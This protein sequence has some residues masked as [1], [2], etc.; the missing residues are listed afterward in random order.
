MLKQ[1]IRLLLSKFYSKQENGTISNLSFPDEKSLTTIVDEQPVDKWGTVCTFTAPSSGYLLARGNKTPNAGRM[2]ISIGC[3]SESISTGSESQNEI[4]LF[5]PLRKG[6]FAKVYANSVKALT[7]QFFKS[8][9]G[10]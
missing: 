7:V 5:V 8:V 6:T 10:G 4:S 9:G 2:N 3:G 1:T